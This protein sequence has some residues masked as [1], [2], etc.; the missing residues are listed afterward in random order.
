[1]ACLHMEAAPR[2]GYLGLDFYFI[3]FGEQS[4]RGPAE[5]KED[6]LPMPEGDGALC[7][8]YKKQE[9]DIC[10]EFLNPTCKGLPRGIFNLIHTKHKR[11]NSVIN[12]H[13]Q[14]QFIVRWD[15]DCCHEEDS[16]K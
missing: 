9:S 1:M 6:V 8:N 16:T 2:P 7:L 14:A 10:S 13:I 3:F 4:A 12:V 5:T 15:G 11:E